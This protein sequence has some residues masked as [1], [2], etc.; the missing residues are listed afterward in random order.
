M[1]KRLRGSK[2]KELIEE[3]ETLIDAYIH[4]AFLDVTEKKKESKPIPLPAALRKIKK[5]K[6]VSVPTINLSVDANCKYEAKL[7][8]AL[9]LSNRFRPPSQYSGLLILFRLWAD[10]TSRS[11]L[12]ATA[13]MES[14]TSNL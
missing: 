7:A 13:Q 8:C 6:F 9:L 5:Q 2:H 11:W 3:I 10:S 14:S 12:S 4:L 1:I